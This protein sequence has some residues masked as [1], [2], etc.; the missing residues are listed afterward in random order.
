MESGRHAD[1]LMGDDPVLNAKSVTALMNALDDV[2]GW[3]L[4][5]TFPAGTPLG[6]L[7]AV[8]IGVVKDP[9]TG[10]LYR[11]T[12]TAS[13]AVAAILSGTVEAEVLGTTKSIVPHRP[14][15]KQTT[16]RRARHD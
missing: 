4:P 12:A 7:W 13:Y 6:E 8:P 11:A 14:V 1:I 15:P 5:R 3:E 10:V 9:V 16:T 2:Y